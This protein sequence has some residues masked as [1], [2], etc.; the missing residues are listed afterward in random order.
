M[1]VVERS[2][3]VNGS[4]RW[5]RWF[6]DSR[7]ILLLM[8]GAY[9]LLL[10]AVGGQ[11][12]WADLGVSPGR[13]TF[14]DLRSVTS[15]WECTRRGIDVLP[16]NPCDPLG[17]PA[18]YPRIW[19]SPAFLGLGEGS[20]VVLGFFVAAAFFIGAL[21]VLP[22]RVNAYE[23]VIYGLALC[24]PAVMLG[25]ERGN[26]DIL[27]FALVVLAVLLLRRSE[28]SRVVGHVLLLFAAMLK[29]FPIFAAVVLLRGR[30]ALIGFG[31]VVGGFLIYAY[32][33]RADLRTLVHVVPQGDAFSYGIR[34]FTEWLAAGAGSIV[35][36]P[37]RVWDGGVAAIIVA[38]A[39]YAYRGGRRSLPR[40]FDSAAQRDFDLFVAGAAVY[41]CSYFLLRNYEYRLVFLL[42]TVPQL[43]RWVRDRRA[44]AIVS[45]LALLGTLW[46]DE[47]LVAKVPLLGRAMRGWNDFSTFA[48][49]NQPL[50]AV[51]IMQL[52]LFAGLIGCLA[53]GVPLRV[54]RSSG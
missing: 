29:L 19:M 54:R 31:L 41:I 13:L 22:A 51:V 17:R 52:T 48:P 26:V 44:L 35:S 46:F 47:L 9:F 32:S 16:A 27:V 34:I 8:L 10:A 21:A 49:F 24:S 5:T 42:M 28:R 14:L 4:G 37:L 2:G 36:F 7:L 25:V 38:V 3:A 45:I 20:T 23:A 30:R 39:L 43:L 6:P 53:A 15:G 33:I 11:P 40:V 50:P 12:H 1:L 18:N